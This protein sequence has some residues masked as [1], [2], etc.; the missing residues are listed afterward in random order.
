MK[1]R[2]FASV[3]QVVAFL[4]GNPVEL[5]EMLLPDGSISKARYDVLYNDLAPGNQVARFLT[6]SGDGLG[7]H[8]FVADY[9]GAG[10]IQARL[11][12]PANRVYEVDHLTAYIEGAPGALT[13]A[14]Y[15][16]LAALAN[17]IGLRIQ[18]GITTKLDIT[19]GHP[20]TMNAGWSTHGATLQWLDAGGGVYA[21]QVELD[22]RIQGKPLILVAG[23][24][25]EVQL[26]DNFVGLVAHTF[27][28]RGWSRVA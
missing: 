12:V 9:S 16:D 21:L 23:Q 2:T 19:A 7:V 27:F 17:G 6:E 26:Q 11:L 5:V 15:G 3:D 13:P 10:A 22:L 20:V 25:L 1:H 8:D 24:A 14:L 28:A 18:Q 4:N